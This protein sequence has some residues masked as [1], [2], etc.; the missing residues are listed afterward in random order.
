MRKISRT[1]PAAIVMPRPGQ[2]LKEMP[3]ISMKKTN[4]GA[5]RQSDSSRLV[6]IV[7]KGSRC[8][9]LDNDWAITL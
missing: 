2:L 9:V 7:P 3:Q 8:F 5:I 4:F 1:F 6:I